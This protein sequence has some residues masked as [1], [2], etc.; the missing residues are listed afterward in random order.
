LPEADQPSP[1]LRLGRPTSARTRTEAEIVAVK[2]TTEEDKI[3]QL[4]NETNVLLHLQ[5]EGI[6]RAYGVYEVKVHHERALAMVL[7]YKPA[8]DLSAWIPTHGFPER[9]AS[10]LMAQVFDAL[11]YLHGLSIVHRD[12]KPG[13]VLCE[14]AKDGSVKAVIADFG[15]A[16]HIMD[17]EKLS[18]RCGTGG[19]VAP[20]MFQMNWPAQVM[21]DLVTD[22][23]KMDVF[24]CG[25]MTYGMTFG[26]NPFAASTLDD[27][28]HRN[29]HCVIDF[30]NMGGRSEEFNSFLSGVCAKNPHRRF[31]SSDALAHP[32]CSAVYGTSRTGDLVDRPVKVKVTW[33]EFEQA[34]NE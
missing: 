24:S 21:A 2:V 20:E 13:N 29:A 6:V 3:S 11:V 27:T 19:F 14:R 25:M 23:T 33:A 4:L 28:Y 34:A 8:M 30:N 22:P 12:I 1:T 18:M 10:T 5:H 32:W 17:K 16:A 26:I 9:V 15:L 7:D 31:T